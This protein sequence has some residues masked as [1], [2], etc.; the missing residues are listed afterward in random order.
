MKPI[1]KFSSLFTSL[2]AVF[3]VTSFEKPYIDRHGLTP[4][5]ISWIAWEEQVF[6]RSL[7]KFQK[8][9]SLYERN[10]KNRITQLVSYYQTGL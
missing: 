6:D 3:V 9:E 4:Y 2:I 7:K 1:M 10:L 5:Q 8:F